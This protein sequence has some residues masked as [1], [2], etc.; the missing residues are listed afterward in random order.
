MFKFSID[1]ALTY[2]I[3]AEAPSKY[4]IVSSWRCVEIRE[5]MWI[6]SGTRDLLGEYEVQVEIGCPA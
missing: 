5:E 2:R 6:S 3:V 1:I 4:G